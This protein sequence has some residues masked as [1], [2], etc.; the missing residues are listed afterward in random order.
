MINVELHKTMTY[1]ANKVHCIS[2]SILILLYCVGIRGRNA[3]KGRTTNP[4]VVIIGY[5]IVFTPIEWSL[6]DDSTAESL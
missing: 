1:L 5:V 2:Y 4:V 6:R 3:G